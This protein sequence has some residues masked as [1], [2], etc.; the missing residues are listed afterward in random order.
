MNR[1]CNALASLYSNLGKPV[2]DIIIFN[3][4]LAK[5]I[6]M[7]GMSGLVLN[8]FVTASIMRMATPSF[9]KLA[10]QEAKLEGDFRTA[11]ARL[12]INAEE[13]AF[14]NGADREL[15]ILNKSYQALVSHINSIYKIRIG[16]NMFE[17]F[18]I[19]YCWSAVRV[20]NLKLCLF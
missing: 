6:G 4:Q 1:F 11:H 15:G 8:Y 2:L 19:K 9:G 3:Y 20:T 10:A 17:D 13:V 5:N 12:L 18:I 16:Y 7:S 14:Y